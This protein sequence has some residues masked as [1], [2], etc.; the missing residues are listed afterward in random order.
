[1]PHVTIETDADYE[2]ALAEIAP[3]FDNVPEPGT[4]EAERFDT[5]ASLI[6]AY[7]AKHHRMDHQ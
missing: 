2:R 7:E 4:P 1:M 5:L 6:A 3:W